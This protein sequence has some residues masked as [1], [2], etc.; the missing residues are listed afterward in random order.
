MYPD[1][2]C[3][4]LCLWPAS[5]AVTLFAFGEKISPFHRFAFALETGH[6]HIAGCLAIH[7][8]TANALV[9]RAWPIVV[10]ASAFRFAPIWIG[11]ALGAH[12]IKAFGAAA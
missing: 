4:A 6:H 1:S 9:A 8:I 12:R 7:I 11:G 10:K 2:L 3:N 5:D